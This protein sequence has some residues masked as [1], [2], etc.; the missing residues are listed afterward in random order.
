[1]KRPDT[2]R[3][4]QTTGNVRN[5]LSQEQLAGIGSV[6]IIYNETE[7]LLDHVL[8]AALNSGVYRELTSRIHGVDGKIAITK[9]AM[10]KINPPPGFLDLLNATLGD[11]GFSLLKRYR[12]AVVH[13]QVLDAP[14]GIGR[15][16]AKRGRIEEVLLTAKALDGLYSRF[17]ILRHELLEAHTIAREL[18]TLSILKPFIGLSETVSGKGRDP[19]RL[20]IESKIQACLSRYRERQSYRLSLP[21]LP[22]FP[23]ESLDQTGTEPSRDKPENP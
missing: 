18:W 5:D 4:V 19:S 6:A 3:K 2:K 1:M 17:E 9:V 8:I 23:E 7:W 14:A 16:A 21:P 11:S 20:K 22:P 12:D 15:T 13:A 10:Q